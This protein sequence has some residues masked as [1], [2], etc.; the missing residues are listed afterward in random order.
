MQIIR[1]VKTGKDFINYLWELP[2]NILGLIVII[3]LRPWYSLGWDDCY[4][5]EKIKNAI[6][7]GTYTIAPSEEY[8]NIC[9]MWH[10]RG[11]RK[12]SKKYGWF[13]IPIVL[14]PAA[15]RDLWDILFH[16]HWSHWKREKWYYSGFPE[17]QADELG[18][19]KRFKE[20]K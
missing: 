12:Q 6:S 3:V 9:V 8:N 5:T 11:H 17:K 2:Q 16:K 14:I 13:Y 1:K 10:E 20:E 18:K 4:F 7:L 19:L 15:V